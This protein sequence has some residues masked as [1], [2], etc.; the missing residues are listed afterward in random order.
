MTT[1]II[2]DRDPGDEDQRRE[3]C[4]SSFPGKSFLRCSLQS[5]HSGPHSTVKRKTIYEWW[6]GESDR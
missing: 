4:C 3:V 2:T 6:G 5:G 1:P